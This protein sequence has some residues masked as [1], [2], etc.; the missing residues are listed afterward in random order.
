[1][2]ASSLQEAAMPGEDAA[3]STPRTGGPSNVITRAAEFAELTPAAATPALSSL[4]TLFGVSV[5]VSVELGRLTLS[6]GEILKLGVGSVVP[7]DRAVSE[8]VD[9]LVQGVR[10]ARGEVVVV[11]DRFAVRIKELAEPKKKP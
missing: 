4:D 1:M 5:A 7:L 8:P 3:R 2:S 9:L 6:L 11:D 10:L